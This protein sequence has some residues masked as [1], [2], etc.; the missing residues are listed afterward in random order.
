MLQPSE[1]V[2]IVVTGRGLDSEKDPAAASVTLDRAAIDRSASGRMED[3]LRDVAGLTSFRRSDSRSAHPT[4]QGLTLRGLGGNAASRV[5][6]SLDGVPQADPFG[7]WVAF[8]AL[9][10]HAIDRIRVTRGA[11]GTE[12]GA[13]AGAID[14]D[15]RA[16]DRDDPIDASLSLGSRQSVDAAQ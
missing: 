3:V 8:T 5:A 6:L 2:T 12:A 15:S 4:S 11:S 1:P 9:D 7:G 16:A 14:I 13:L 10:P